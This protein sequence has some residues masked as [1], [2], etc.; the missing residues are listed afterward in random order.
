MITRLQADSANEMAR[1]RDRI[2]AFQ[3]HMN[4][5]RDDIIHLRVQ[6]ARREQEILNLRQQLEYERSNQSRTAVAGPGAISIA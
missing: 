1:L 4:N 6:L 2:T 5:C 3:R